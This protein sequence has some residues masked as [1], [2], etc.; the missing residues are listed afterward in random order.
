VVFEIT[1]MTD[2][3]SLQFLN[4]TGFSNP[5]VRTL[6]TT[7]FVGNPSDLANNQK[8]S[9]ERP[10]NLATH[11][12]D[13]ASLVANNRALLRQYLPQEPLW[14]NQVHGVAVA[15][16]STA[17]V[18]PFG[19]SQ[20]PTADAAITL[21]PKR[22]LA[23][24]TADCLPVVFASVAN[25]Q[26]PYETQFHGVAAAHAGWRGLVNGVLENTVASLRA[27]LA[28][29]MAIEASFGAAIG[30][31]AFEVGA[32]VFQAFCEQAN[33]AEQLQKNQTAF[34]P[35]N[36]PSKQYPEKLLSA[37][38]KWLANLYQ[39]A[40]IRLE[41]IGVKVLAQPDW[42]T[43]RDEQRFFSHRRDTVQQRE[44]NLSGYFINGA[45]VA[46]ET[47]FNVPSPFRPGRQATL[48][49]LDR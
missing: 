16:D 25:P 10:F 46:P 12:G 45:S 5:A 41:Q 19:A 49:W 11:V 6:L 43:Y 32:D 13:D 30:P 27:Q 38:E 4:C 34:K 47:K 40:Q 21:K 18:N 44:G 8:H 26:R 20:I 9:S 23:V 22:V 28:P 24:L 39:L 31:L 17:T 48:I 42:C 33:N 14:L 36:A 2:D 29:G 1:A 3:S 7:R 35:L 15:D 37:P